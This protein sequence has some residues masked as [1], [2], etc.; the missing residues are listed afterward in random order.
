VVRYLVEEVVITREEGRW[1]AKRD[2][3]VEMRIPDGL[4]DVIGKR[5]SG[6]SEGCGKVLSVAAVIGRDFRLEALQKVAGMSDEDISQALEE[7]RKMAVVEEC[8]GAGA[9]VNYRFAHAFFR[10][11]LYDEIIA[12]RRIRFHQQVA[13]ALEE[14]YKARLEEHAAELAEHFSHSSDPATVSAGEAVLRLILSLN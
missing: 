3:P 9:V 10:Q 2:T 5:L 6:L 12:P 4:R 8:T 7:A 1:R 11:T 14:V 13:R